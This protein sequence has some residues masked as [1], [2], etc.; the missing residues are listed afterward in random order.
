M[1]YQGPNFFRYMF[2]SEKITNSLCKEVFLGL[3]FGIG[4]PQK[5][6]ATVQCGTMVIE[7]NIMNDNK[8]ND[9]NY[10]NDTNNNDMLQY[11]Y[12]NSI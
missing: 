8:N 9:H 5:N 10:N 3:Y 11:F 2:I 7:L 6:L 12:H 4:C 1:Y